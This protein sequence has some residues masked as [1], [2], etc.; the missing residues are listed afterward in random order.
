MFPESSLAVYVKLADSK[1]I[2]A[3]CISWVLEQGLEGFLEE[4][5]DELRQGGL[6]LGEGELGPQ[7][8]TMK[9]VD[10]E[11]GTPRLPAKLT[12]SYPS[13]QQIAWGWLIVSASN[14]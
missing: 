11:A 1:G 3:G 6:W 2:S 4:V 10:G 14:F 5:T 7:G 8:V 9:L 13:N 12:L